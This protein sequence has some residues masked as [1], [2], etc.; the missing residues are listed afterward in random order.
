MGSMLLLQP[1]SAILGVGS[2]W[3]LGRIPAAQLPLSG[4]SWWMGNVLGQ[5]I[6]APALLVL[7]KS[8]R[9]WVPGPLFS[10]LALVVI[11]LLSFGMFGGPS[12]P[13]FALALAFYFPLVVLIAVRF[14]LE[15]SALS[16]LG[17]STAVITVT[18]FGRGPFQS[19]WVELDLFLAGSL[20]ALALGALVNER[21][22]LE[23]ALRRQNTALEQAN[24]E[25]SSALAE[26][27]TLEGL[28]PI[29]GWCKQIRDDN[30]YW[31]G[32]EQYFAE[33]S[34]VHFTHGICPSCRAK[35]F[36]ESA[37]AE[38]AKGEESSSATD[39]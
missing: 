19:S 18:S 35:Y 31:N 5:C 15:G 13:S 17:L 2:L 12:L 30:G 39:A 32:I 25:L 27:Q 22:S 10:M 21:R 20:T 11:G 6:V 4:F 34:H 24:L 8:P 7:S 3:A 28:L 26:V 1:F 37:G 16:G 29:C 9:T 36:G 14:G 23:A 33:R 38:D